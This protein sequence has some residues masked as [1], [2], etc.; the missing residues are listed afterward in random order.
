MQAA[1]KVGLLVVVF[2]GL[3]VATYAVLEKSF[4]AK[5]TDDYYV[6]FD[7]AGG[8]EPGARVL[9]AGVQIGAVTK[10]ELITAGQA[11]ATIAV[12]KNY[13]IPVGS[14]A[15]LPTSFISIGDR[16]VEIMPPPN[17][18]K[19]AMLKPGDK[20]PGSLASPLAN[21]IP[22]SE[23]TV[24]ELNKT[25]VAFRELVQDPE[26]KKSLTS[27]M[28]SSEKTAA[29]FGGL[30][31]R[32]DALLARNTDQFETMLATTA[33]S[34]ENLQAVS[35]QVRKLVE[36]GDIQDRT[37][38]LL[39]NLNAAVESGQKLVAEMSSLAGDPEMRSN[40]KETLANV[41]TMSE[42]GTRIASNAETITQNGVTVSDEAVKLARKANELA[43]KVDSLIETFKTTLERFKSGGTGLVNDTHFTADLVRETDP[44]RLRTDL[45]VIFPFGQERLQ[46]GLYDAAESNKLN[47]QFGR[48]VSKS[49]ALRYGVYA[50]KPAVGVDYA[51]AP[52][53]NLRSDLFGLNEPQLD[54]R[55]AYQYGQDLS[56]WL[57]IER[58]FQRPMAAFGIGIKK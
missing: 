25:L 10:V 47:L 3:L 27:L 18:E 40:M 20:I 4:F 42:S 16:Q 14:R 36:S 54:F 44:G 55:L 58:I 53:L 39:D 13:Q 17:A 5:P 43:E 50:S 31:D 24:E 33:T 19:V 37:V 12:E 46:V 23:K 30:A 48:D 7:N 26:L 52:R 38:K 56:A 34:L 2:V 6:V 22:N 29:S 35:Y 11:Q 15:V 8:L 45:N 41:K 28:G 21:L 32:M 1:W 51:L 57:G 9:F 49:M